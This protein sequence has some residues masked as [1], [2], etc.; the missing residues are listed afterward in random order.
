MG[1]SANRS[2]I[3]SGRAL[4]SSS[5]RSVAMKPGQMLLTVIPSIA[6]SSDSLGALP[7]AR[8]PFFPAR[9]GD[10]AA[11]AAG[12]AAHEG[13]AARQTEVHS[14]SF[15]CA[16]RSRLD[17]GIH[18]EMA[19]GMVAILAFIEEPAVCPDLGGPQNLLAGAQNNPHR[20]I[21]ECER[22]GCHAP[23]T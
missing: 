17:L 12:S 21:V 13:D 16:K 22:K 2:F 18:G 3:I 7:G 14:I 20:F 5:I 11:D 10:R 23:W 9:G 6:T 8:R 19:M 4:V 15:T 1:I